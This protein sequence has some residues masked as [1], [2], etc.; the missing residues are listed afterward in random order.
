MTPNQKVTAF[1][2]GRVIFWLLALFTGWFLAFPGTSILAQ[3][4]ISNAI[5][6]PLIF[7][8]ILATNGVV[9]M[10]NAEFRQIIGR[11]AIFKANSLSVSF[12][13]ER[14]A[15]AVL[16][17]LPITPTNP[18]AVPSPNLTTNSAPKSLP[19]PKIPGMA[20]IPGGPFTLG[21][22]IGDPDITDADPLPVNVSA[23]YMDVNLVTLSRWQ[24]IHA[25]A[26]NHGYSFSH[27]GAGKAAYHPVHSIDWF[28]AIKWCNAL[29]QRAGRVPVYCL[30]P[31]LKLVFTS[32]E[33]ARIFANW[34]ANGYRLPTEAEWE[35]AA[36]GGVSGQR[37]PWGNKI[38]QK[39]ANY[40][41]NPGSFAYDG[42]PGGNN[43]V[44]AIGGNSPATSPV[45]SFPPNAFG[46]YDMAGNLDAWCWDFGGSPYG[47]GTDP[48]GP[49][50]GATHIVRGG[51]WG[52]TPAICRTANRN[53]GNPDAGYDRIGFRCV[54]NAPQ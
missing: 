22:A 41:G 39:L 32:G 25:W 3:S 13:L 20:R 19:N 11:K 4:T 49:E 8:Q 48:H 40:T 16:A 26:T 31:A 30:D 24:A 29:S 33:G 10:T 6:S 42:G 7:E 38:E 36:R 44:G 14:L 27:P 47:G 17:R 28:D 45:G 37:F 2:R 50:S 5:T 53:G 12:D 34:S 9:L 52:D 43:P 51:S 15:P 1:S 21:N 54:L 23:F 35:K 46:L 18:Q